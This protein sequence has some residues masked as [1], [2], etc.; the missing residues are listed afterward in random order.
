MSSTTVN[1][2]EIT[3]FYEDDTERKI[4]LPELDESVLPDIKGRVLAINNGTAQ[5]VNDFKQT[6]VSNDGA[7]C[8]SISAAKIIMTV[9]EVVYSG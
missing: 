8:V 1:S 4:T 7:S 9:E 3:L 2:A 5:Y 6:F